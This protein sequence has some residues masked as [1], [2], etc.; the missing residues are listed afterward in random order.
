VEEVT[1]SVA[2]QLADI[3]QHWSWVREGLVEIQDGGIPTDELPEDVYAACVNGQAHLWAHPDYFAITKFVVEHGERCLLI[4][5]SWAREKGNK[6][7]LGWHP[8]LE[9]IAIDNGC[10]KMAVHTPHAPLVDYCITNLDYAVESYILTKRV[11]EL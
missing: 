5:K 10:S 8:F 9:Q 11:G 4:W 7:S 6:T 1:D 2:P 3:R